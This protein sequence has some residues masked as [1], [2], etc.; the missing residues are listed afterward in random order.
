[1]EN[2]AIIKGESQKRKEIQVEKIDTKHQQ[3]R[4]RIMHVMEK[5]IKLL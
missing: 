1:M 2:K 4:E 3:K 5:L